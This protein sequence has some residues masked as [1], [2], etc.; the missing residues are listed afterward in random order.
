MMIRQAISIERSAQVR[1]PPSSLLLR[2][3]TVPVTVTTF[4]LTSARR[5]RRHEQVT[6]TACP[7]RTSRTHDTSLLYKYTY[8]LLAKIGSPRLLYSSPQCDGRLSSSRVLD[9]RCVSLLMQQASQALAIEYLQLKRQRSIGQQRQRH[10]VDVVTVAS[11]S[12]RVWLCLRVRYI[13]RS[14]LPIF[15]AIFVRRCNSL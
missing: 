7:N 14:A 11:V 9:V 12:R 10:T 15:G 1:R 4:S 6:A 5:A 13:R 8:A 2:D 3:M